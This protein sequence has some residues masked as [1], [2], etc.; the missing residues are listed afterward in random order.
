MRDTGGWGRK[1]VTNRQTGGKVILQ[2]AVVFSVIALI[3]ALLGFGGIAAGA[4]EVAKVRFFIILLLFVASLVMGLMRR[5][6]PSNLA[7]GSPP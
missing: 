3:A 2:Y 5:G 4:A 1:K 7:I 6:W